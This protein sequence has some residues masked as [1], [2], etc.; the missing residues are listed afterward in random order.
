MVFEELKDFY[1]DHTSRTQRGRAQSIA[2]RARTPRA[3]LK[4]AGRLVRLGISLKRG[5]S[6]GQLDQIDGL[7][8]L[9]GNLTNDDLA[10]A[11][12]EEAPMVGRM[13][14]TSMV[15]RSPR[16]SQE[17]GREEQPT[18]DATLLEMKA[19]RLPELPKSRANFTPPG[20]Q[21]TA[22]RTPRTSERDDESAF[23]TASTA[24]SET[25]P[26]PKSSSS[27]KAS[28]LTFS[29]D[30]ASRCVLA[31]RHA[32]AQQLLA[33]IRSHGS[34]HTHTQHSGGKSVLS[35]LFP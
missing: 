2:L 3:R 11:E 27:A 26:T 8:N 28:S 29:K 33:R 34:P 35:R 14:T 32:H 1:L 7:Q 13:G 15:V 4:K 21:G 10:H 20:H 5:M 23:A 22:H 25:A 18:R 17:R 30:S 19:V 6:H 24:S 9:R 12:E 16:T 31:T